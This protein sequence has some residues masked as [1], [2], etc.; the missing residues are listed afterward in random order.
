MENSKAWYLSRTVWAVI[1]MAVAAMLN[2]FGFGTISEGD[3]QNLVAI[4]LS[5]VQGVAAI[6]AIIGRAVASTKITLA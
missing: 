5:V 2:Q 3:Q 1:V 4:I 6:V